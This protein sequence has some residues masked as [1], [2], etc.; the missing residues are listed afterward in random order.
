MS[1]D[2]WI[3]V[4]VAGP[5]DFTKGLPVLRVAHKSK[6]GS[7]THSFHFPEKMEDTINT[8]YDIKKDPGQTIPVSD[9]KI[10]D[11]LNKELMRLIKENDAPK[12]TIIRM[13]ES[14]GIN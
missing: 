5:F 9:K 6:V 14:T 4:N 3:F 13:S 10:I 7:K 2:S 1:A 11:R 8:V 12:E